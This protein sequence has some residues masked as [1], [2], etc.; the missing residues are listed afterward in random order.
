MNAHQAFVA[1]LNVPKYG[2]VFEQPFRPVSIARRNVFVI[3]PKSYKSARVARLCLSATTQISRLLIA[4]KLH[5]SLPI[6]KNSFFN[7]CTLERMPPL[8]NAVKRC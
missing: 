8:K 7:F 4:L 5:L 2:P 1:C 6:T 3:R